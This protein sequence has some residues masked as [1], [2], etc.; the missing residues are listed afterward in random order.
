ME[1]CTIA[2]ECERGGNLCVEKF[3]H[4]GHH[5]CSIGNHKCQT[6]CQIESCKF[7]CSLNFDHSIKENHNCGN[8][9]P[10]PKNCED[11]ACGRTC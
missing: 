11:L 4:E 10:C 3:G 1:K 7:I 8:K 5:R 2:A 6:R 9:H